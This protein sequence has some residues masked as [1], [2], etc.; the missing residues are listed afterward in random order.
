MII[1]VSIA[2]LTWGESSKCQFIHPHHVSPEL[3]LFTP[4]EQKDQSREKKMVQSHM[5]TKN[6]SHFHSPGLQLP[7]PQPTAL[8]VETRLNA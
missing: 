4:C 2:L 7:S 5:V 3:R 1:W 6:Y 8:L